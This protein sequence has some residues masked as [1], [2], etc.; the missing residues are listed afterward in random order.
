MLVS[1]GVEPS[2]SR[3]AALLRALRPW[4]WVKNAAVLL[5]VLFGRRLADPSAVIG[6][7]AATLA[8]CAAA[9]ANYLWN[10]VIDRDVDRMHPAKRSR[11]V[12]SGA[13]PVK[14]AIAVA[15]ALLIVSFVIAALA[16]A[17]DRRGVLAYLA[18]YA[19]LGLLYSAFAKRIPIVDVIVI[20]T[21]FLLRVLAGGAASGVIVS[22]WL[23]GCA[24][25]V[26]VFLAFGKRAAEATRFG[27]GGPRLRAP[28]TPL[29]A[30]SL[31]WA[32]GVALI[33]AYVAYTIAPRTVHEFG[34]RR[35][36]WTAP[37][38]IAG[39]LRASWCFTHSADGEDPARLLLRDR[40]L[41]LAALAWIVA[42]L[43]LIAPW[44][45]S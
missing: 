22:S 11:P 37:I 1:G 28:Y 31:A 29:V 21:G 14:T 12:A 36:L 20:G 40:W 24:S 15:R 43:A 35:L 45:S 23:I 16:P 7:I 34:S 27:A 26:A 41:R 32:A 38:A 2:E 9:S 17:A 6:A 39:V 5:P 18:A 30:R 25:L 44:R 33:G 3:A 4:Q 13:L 19:V 10:D 42:D 8:F